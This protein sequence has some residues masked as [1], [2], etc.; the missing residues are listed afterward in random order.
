MEN[1]LQMESK[2]E[3]GGGHGIRMRITERSVLG[4][5]TAEDIKEI[6]G[7]NAKSCRE[8]TKVKSE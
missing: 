8:L 5:R 1:A 7:R 2:E 6:A 3:R 4:T